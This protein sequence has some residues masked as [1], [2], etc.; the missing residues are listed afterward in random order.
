MPV[1]GARSASTLPMVMIRPPAPRCATA[2][3][4]ATKICAH[5]YREKPVVFG[6]RELLDPCVMGGACVV[7]EDIEAAQRRHG[8]L[9]QCGA[10]VGIPEIGD[11][12]LNPMPFLLQG[13][14][15]R[16]EVPGVV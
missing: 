4:I 11:P 6:H 1:I 15:R 13:P 10:F 8:P 3:W 7:H 5:V 14:G 2:A 16:L 9:H 12:R